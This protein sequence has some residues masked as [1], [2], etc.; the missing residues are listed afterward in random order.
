[1]A[2]IYSEH[3]LL[4]RVLKRFNPKR[5]RVKCLECGKIVESK[6]RHDFQACGCSNGVFCDGG[7]DYFRRGASRPSKM[8][9]VLDDD[10]L[11]SSVTGR[12]I[13]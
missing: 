7:F 3:D 13:N 12:K 1:M 8:A 11:I 5:N 2:N 4:N 6:N 9:I 10:S